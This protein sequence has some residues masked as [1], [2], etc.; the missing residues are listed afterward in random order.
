M[1]SKTFPFLLLMLLANVSYSQ[2]NRFENLLEDAKA[3]IRL[4]DFKGAIQSYDEILA[5][6]S[7][8]AEVLLLKG[9]AQNY[10][11][12][13]QEALKTINRAIKIPVPADLLSFRAEIYLNLQNYQEAI[14]DLNIAIKTNPSSENYRLKGMAYMHQKKYSI[15][16]KLLDSALTKNIKNYAC[17]SSLITF[18][19][20]TNNEKLLQNTLSIAEINMPQNM[21]NFMFSASSFYKQNGNLAKAIEY[22]EKSSKLNRYQLLANLEQERGRSDKYLENY[23]KHNAENEMKDNSA[24][25]N[26]IA[27]GYRLNGRHQ[28]A[29]EYYEKA[30][31]AY[32]H[33]VFCE[34]G[35]S[36]I[37]NYRN[38]T[39]SCFKELDH[40]ISAH[41][42]YAI[43]PLLRAYLNTHWGLY[44]KAEQDLALAAKVDSIPLSQRR[45]ESSQAQYLFHHRANLNIKQAKYNQALINLDKAISFEKHR[46]G[47]LYNAKAYVFAKLAKLDSAEI[48]HKLSLE[49]NHTPYYPFYNV[50]KAIDQKFKNKEEFLAVQFAAPS[51]D[52]NYLFESTYHIE[53]NLSPFIKVRIIGPQV[54][55][56][57]YL[58]ILNDGKNL[59]KDLITEEKVEK[60]SFLIE[61]QP[62]T[63]YSF[64]LKPSSKT[65]HLKFAY[66]DEEGQTLIIK[67][68]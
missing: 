10:A 46:F 60:A 31:Q 29:L 36:L 6:D 1:C 27:Y 45:G 41:S 44:E 2:P 49:K 21:A 67:P 8:N 28:K 24:T 20:K 35:K 55:K 54:F 25:L 30:L 47:E 39:A 12:K 56:R 33:N 18:A 42:K 32:K 7:T 53:N 15:A 37:F 5:M 3:R 22:A 38:D 61:N 68:E 23:L 4:G 50:K 34:V 63:E 19:A 51:T 40:A 62:V 66:Q 11:G 16:Y 13:S 59:N 65:I 58:K 64:K 57:E 26:N 43:A 9:K 17:Y 52:V 48:Y 14:D